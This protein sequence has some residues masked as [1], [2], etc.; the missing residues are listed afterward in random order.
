MIYYINT[1]LACMVLL[2]ILGQEPTENH[3]DVRNSS[4]VAFQWFISVIISNAEIYILGLTELNFRVKWW[5]WVGGD[6]GTG[7]IKGISDDHIDLLK[8][9]SI[10]ENKNN[11]FSLKWTRF[12]CVSYQMLP[13][14]FNQNKRI[15]LLHNTWLIWLDTK[16]LDWTN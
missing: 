8:M 2:L 3:S 10:Y 13:G 11:F 12:P 4:N 14:D 15:L 1:P 5:R 6:E 7:N 9:H 16:S